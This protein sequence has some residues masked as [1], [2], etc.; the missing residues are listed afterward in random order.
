MTHGQGFI[1]LAAV[2]IGRWTPIGAFGAALLFSTTTAL[3]VAIGINPPTGSLGGILGAIPSQVFG[4]LPY[5][6]T[7]VVLAGF[8]GHSVAPAAD[9][10]PYVKEART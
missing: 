9:G 2:I 10:Q 4:A 7:I 6:V 3:Q 5:I 8:I 1:A